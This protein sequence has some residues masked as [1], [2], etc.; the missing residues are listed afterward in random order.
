MFKLWNHQATTKIKESKY[1]WIN[2]RWER[3]KHK[4]KYYNTCIEA[5]QREKRINHI[6]KKSNKHNKII[7][8]TYQRYKIEKIILL[9]MKLLGL[10][11]VYMM[12]KES[13]QMI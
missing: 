2:E 7:L 13:N 1:C 11:E 10:L 5:T 12:V 6:E 8:K 4:F 9:L 3:C